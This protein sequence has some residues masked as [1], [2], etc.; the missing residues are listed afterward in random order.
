[1]VS[2]NLKQQAKNSRKLIILVISLLQSIPAF[3]Q[4]VDTAWARVYN[5]P[6][7][8]TDLAYAKLYVVLAMSMRQDIVTAVGQSLTISGDLFNKTLPK[9]KYIKL[10]FVNYYQEVK[11]E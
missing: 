4:S 3:A 5:R 10:T 1:M 7:V 11:N 6:G 9:E 2:P 8:P